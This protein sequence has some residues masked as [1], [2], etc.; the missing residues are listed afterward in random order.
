MFLQTTLSLVVKGLSK[1]SR[2]SLKELSRSLAT[3]RERIKQARHEERAR[4]V[5]IEDPD[6]RPDREVIE[7]TG[8]LSSRD[9][10]GNEPP[11]RPAESSVSADQP[12]RE[13]S[14]DA[15]ISDLDSDRR[16]HREFVGEERESKRVRINA[17]DD[18]ES[19]EWVETEEEWV[20]I[21]RRPRDLFSLHDSQGGP[22][23]CDISKRRESIV[24]SADGGERR[25]VD[26]W[27]RQRDVP[28]SASRGDRKHKIQKVLGSAERTNAATGRGTDMK[29][30]ILDLMLP[31]TPVCREERFGFGE[32]VTPSSSSS[33]SSSHRLP[34]TLA[35][36]RSVSHDSL[37]AQTCALEGPG[38]SKTPQ[39]FTKRPPER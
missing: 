10:A 26:R 36:L 24:C 38:A 18:G 22:K 39:N 7:G 12:P 8:V 1:N 32:V 33:S 14:D 27:G 5:R 17:F 30:D 13:Q 20:R 6:Q 15:D 16:R 21:H 31:P 19:D 37:S 25:I 35:S 3:E 28:R 4:D 11:S 9:G 23:L 29:G 2:R 34:K